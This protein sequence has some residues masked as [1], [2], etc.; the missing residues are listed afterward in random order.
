M[1]C[2]LLNRIFDGLDGALARKQ[3][4]TDAGGFLDISLD[5]LFY[6][7]IPLGFIFADPLQNAIAGAV[8]IFTFV[9]TGSSFLAFAILASKHNIS[10]PVY[11]NKSF[12]YMTGLTGGTETVICFVIMCLFPLYFSTIAYVFA[13]M[14][15]FTTF[16]RI[17]SGYHTLKVIA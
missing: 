13:A 11:K 10:D 9:G 1:I 3:G 6:S 16:S 15:L 14:C 17:Y 8:L 5:F 12:Y 7:L 4:I 2:I